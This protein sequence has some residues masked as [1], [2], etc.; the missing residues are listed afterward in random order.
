MKHLEII[1]NKILNPDELR[2]IME[3]KQSEGKTFAFSNGI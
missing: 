3:V 1:K 2:S